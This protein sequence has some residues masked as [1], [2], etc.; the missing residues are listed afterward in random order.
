MIGDTY[1]LE[2]IMH[3][4]VVTSYYRDLIDFSVCV[5]TVALN[6]KSEA[7]SIGF[8]E[9]P[10]LEFFLLYHQWIKKFFSFEETTNKKH[11]LDIRFFTHRLVIK[12]WRNEEKHP[13]SV[14]PLI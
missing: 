2:Q 5:N 3:I 7:I 12:K 14:I 11:G 6:N 9:R 4:L 13:K 1:L 8:D 10:V